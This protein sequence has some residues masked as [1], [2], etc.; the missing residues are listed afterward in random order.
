MKPQGV[1]YLSEGKFDC[2][3][4]L[5]L[6]FNKIGDECLSHIANGFFCKLIL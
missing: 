1:F 5:N 6:N 3:L 2:L 4:S